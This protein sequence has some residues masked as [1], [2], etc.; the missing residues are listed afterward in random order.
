MNSV[1]QWLSRRQAPP[2]PPRS[3]GALT[4]SSP[5]STRLQVH[6]PPYKPPPCGFHLS[7][8]LAE[9]LQT[10]NHWNDRQATIPMDGSGASIALIAG[11]SCTSAPCPPSKILPDARYYLVRY[12]RWIYGLVSGYH[13][14]V[15][16]SFSSDVRL[17][18]WYILTLFA[19]LPQHILRDS[20][21]R[22]SNRATCSSF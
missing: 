5:P 1:L 15:C 4:A 12:L 11:Q 13:P 20:V 2:C 22:G 7:I 9:G 6:W 8:L 16:P 19:S 17:S 10:P 21:R 3:H 14:L 18:T